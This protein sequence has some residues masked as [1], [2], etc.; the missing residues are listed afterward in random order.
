MTS[1][2]TDDEFR[3]PQEKNL[4][5]I[6]NTIR[7]FNWSKYLMRMIVVV[8][9]FITAF[10]F[11]LFY[12]IIPAWF[13]LNY[14]ILTYANPNILSVFLSNYAHA[15]TE[16]LQQ[17]MI[18]YILTILM[19]GAIALIAVPHSN[20][21]AGGKLRCRFGT[22]T[23]VQS[24]LVFFIVVPFIISGVSIISGPLLG[25]PH[26]VGF[27][28][29]SY[30]FEGFLVYICEILIIRKAQVMWNRGDKKWAVYGAVIG[31]ILIV[32]P[33]V[34]MHPTANSNYIAH[35]T[36]FVAGFMTPFLIERLKGEKIQIPTKSSISNNGGS[37]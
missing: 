37:L 2:H 18:A 24:T 34:F 36:G 7:G 32:T 11:C 4:C 26:G 27:S 33:I 13:T 15:N 19:I 21:K 3:I 31:L 9:I 30:A 23:L 28:G 6:N 8:P 12:E 35:L 5:M 17:N 14:V 25:V 16:H 10:N 22:K 1:L 20:R 29:V